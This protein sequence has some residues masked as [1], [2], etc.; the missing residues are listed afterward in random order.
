MLW[1]NIQACKKMA[2]A[3][4]VLEGNIYSSYLEQDADQ[5]ITPRNFSVMSLYSLSAFKRVRLTYPK[6][7]HYPY[8]ISQL[9]DKRQLC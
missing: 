4:G 2:F 8:C 7:Q 6:E 1:K 3:Y 5:I 9:R